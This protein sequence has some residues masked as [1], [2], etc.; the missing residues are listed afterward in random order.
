M[1]L[2][3]FFF[4]F[5]VILSSISIA[6]DKKLDSL[7]NEV[8]S[9][10]KEDTT[11]VRLLYEY[12]L[13]YDNEVNYDSMQSI[14]L[15]VD[16]LAIKLEDTVS[17][18]KSLILKGRFYNKKADYNK[19][20]ELLKKAIKLLKSTN[21]IEFNYYL[22]STIGSAYYR[23]N[24]LNKQLD[25]SLVYYK[26]SLNDELGND[27][28]V[29]SYQR[30][31][32]VY[33]IIGDTAMTSSYSLKILAV[34]R[35]NDKIDYYLSYYSS[36]GYLHKALK[37][38]DSVIFY[39]KLGYTKL[40]EHKN[41]S[42]TFKMKLV[43]QSRLLGGAFYN[44]KEY[45]SAIVY[46]KPCLELSKEISD[47]DSYKAAL[48]ILSY[49]YGI[50]SEFQKGLD[51]ARATI[52]YGHQI[53]DTALIARSKYNMTYIYDGLKD[54]QKATEINNELIADYL[55]F[56]PLRYEEQIYTNQCYFYYEA[57][58]YKNAIKY[59]LKAYNFNSEKPTTLY[60]LA[61]AYLAAYKD[62][63]IKIQEVT[64]EA[65]N[66][67]SSSYVLTD[68]EARQKVL[69]L[70]KGYYEKSI[71]LLIEKKVDKD[72]VHPHL[73]LGDYYDIVGNDKK[74]I[75]HYEKA[76]EYSKG[77][78]VPFKD[79]LRVA[80]RL[81]ELNKQKKN[82]SATLKWLEIRDSLEKVDASQNDL[83][84]L[85]KKQ[86][87]FEY[88]QKLYADSLEQKQK[89]LAVKYEQEKQTL[90]LKS[91]EEK[92][93]Y[94]YGGLLLLAIFLFVLYRRFK[95]AL[96]QKE[97]IELQKESIEEKRIALRKT[98]EG[99]QD[100]INYSKRIQKAVFPS[101]EKVKDLFPT[102]FLFFKP[103]D[104]VS[105]D[106]YWVH[107]VAGKKII[108]TA[109]CT[110]HGVPGAFM[111][112]I[113]INILKE[114]VQE[115]ITDAAIILKE[116]NQRL[117][118]R[119]SQNGKTSVK[120]GMDLALCILDSNTIEF[121]GA[122]LPLYHVR[123]GELI[124]Y[125]GSNIFLGSKSA[126]PEPKVHHIPYQP[127]D[128]IYMSTDGL[129]DQKG[130]EKGKKFYSKRLKD[131][132][133]SNSSLTMEGQESKLHSLRSEWLMGKYEQLDDIT[134]VGVQL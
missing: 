128:L 59:G 89:D 46:L 125:K 4:F 15:K 49:L 27:Q 90:K 16:R 114:I 119:L 12:H 70:L 104:I 123:E 115:G 5:L 43:F 129:P 26:K 96:K 31:S 30:L 72:L 52:D 39:Y 92:K 47:M 100:S 130:G 22:N 8:Y 98:H 116:I 91:E 36:M 53:G 25:S 68:L 37:N 14:Q 58:D 110:G 66:S 41:D 64:P 29:N 108:V 69:E 45:D 71:E 86:A 61:D 111:T 134:V 74:V 75:Y 77:D 120:D 88:S 9:Y 117:I 126:M 107:E 83:A 19:E 93:Y 57:K 28:K 33:S 7:R 85:G 99:I 34:A 56:L 82:T 65:L 127:G 113:G 133:L 21:E 35:L 109:D 101:M 95:I 73:G 80:D 48:S 62:T 78:G 60:N 121:V 54:Y 38:N 6:Q 67:E 18:V 103:K 2:R 11:K 102:S 10:P 94:L 118:D 124:E 112:I 97:V 131:F 105:G 84:S 1:V 132:L 55:S 20:I 42:E 81:Y 23:L 50:R 76:W 63:T 87:E 13:A 3:I 32:Q 44:Y 106:F 122:H 79:Q 51:L 40:L 24:A 17:M